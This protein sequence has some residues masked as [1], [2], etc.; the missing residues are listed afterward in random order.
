MDEPDG[1]GL[2][3]GDHVHDDLG[4]DAAECVGELA[5]VM[6][7]ADKVIDIDRQVGVSLPSVEDGDLMLQSDQPTH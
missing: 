6:A 5:E 3:E 4:A 7:V 2:G 1:V